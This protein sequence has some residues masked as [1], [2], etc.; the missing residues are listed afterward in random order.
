[1]QVIGYRRVSTVGQV[2]GEGLGVQ[3]EKIEGWCRYQGLDLV[4]TH[5]DAGLSGAN[6]DRPGLQAALAQVTALGK[7]G[8][9]VAA[10]LDRLGRNAIEVQVTLRD[11]LASGVQGCSQFR[12]GC[13][14][15]AYK[16]ILRQLTRVSVAGW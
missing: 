11:L 13:T 6:M 10:R 7:D 15:T 12:L 5:E 1:M 4:Q 16:G 3:T 8:V 2:D 9:L 14:V